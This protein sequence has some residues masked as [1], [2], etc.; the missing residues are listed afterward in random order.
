[1]LKKDIKAVLF[2]V[3]DT[4]FDRAMA[5]K[6]VLDLI[7]KKLPGIFS[8]LKPERVLEAYLESDRVSTERFNAGATSEGIRDLRNRLFLQLLG[9]K[10]D[11]AAMI[12]EMY[13]RDYPKVKTPVA[14]A[15]PLVKK[16]SRKFRLGVV[17]N[18]LSDV[19]YTKL[20]T[21]GLRDLF[22]CVVLSEEFGIR[23]PDSKI[24]HH[25]VSFLHLQPAECLYVGDSYVND[26]I[27]AK[28]AGMQTCWFN[29]ESLK[30]PDEN[31]K[32]DFIV[33]KLEEL[34]VLL[35]KYEQT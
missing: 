14:G 9:L 24:F 1:M 10:E 26:V 28:N 2:D 22:S 27:G 31:I 17:S 11:L 3:D 34:L 32:P 13:V 18:G 20:E 30:P 15:I 5:Q 33:N 7:V 29:P 16:L 12:S 19:Q 35:E 23:K 4:L 8:G 21:M 25:A 6:T